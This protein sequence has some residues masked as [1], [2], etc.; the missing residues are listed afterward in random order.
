M[1]DNRDPST[2]GGLLLG[3]G[4]ALLMILCCAGP[5][6]VAAGVLTGIG[7]FLRNPWVMGA[8]LVLLGLAVLGIAR[9]SRGDSTDSCCAPPT[10]TSDT[11]DRTIHDTTD[12]PTQ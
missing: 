9:R 11:T 8:G 10:H 4:A 1:N 6:L 2:G 7:G 12:G 5:A 3:G